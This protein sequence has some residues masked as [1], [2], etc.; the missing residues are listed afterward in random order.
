MSAGGNSTQPEA[1]HC[2][3]PSRG[4]PG[5]CLA[6][7]G[8]ASFGVHV[9]GA[10][11]RFCLIGCRDASNPPIT[12]GQRFRDTQLSLFGR[13]GS[14]W[15]VQDIFIGTDDLRYARIARTSDLSERKTVSVA[16][17]GDRRRF[18]PI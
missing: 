18:V 10:A 3:S 17:L 12:P 5:T 16:V 2:P 15:M 9:P 7:T 14:E 13:L 11:D 4:C 1:F 8:G 6:V